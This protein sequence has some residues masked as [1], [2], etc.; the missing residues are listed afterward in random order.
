MASILLLQIP[1]LAFAFIG[2][3]IIL[4]L[5]ILQYS[6]TYNE[7]FRISDLSFSNGAVI[8]KTL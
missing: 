6:I 3:W 4:S 2:E 5:G 1:S 7:V 8:A